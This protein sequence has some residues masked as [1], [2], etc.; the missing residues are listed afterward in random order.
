MENKKDFFS[1]IAII[2]GTC[3]G[4]GFLGIPYVASK[5]GFFVALTYLIIFSGIILLVNL[6]LGEIILRTKKTHQLSG[7]CGK[8]LGN[9]GKK[10]MTFAT[11]FTIYSIMI[12]YMIGIGESIG[13]LIFNEIKYHIII[14]VFFGLIM[15]SL[16][17]KGIKELKKVEKTGIIS[18]IIILLLIVFLFSEKVDFANLQ[19]FNSKFILFP[20][21]VILFSL[22]SF[23]SLPQAKIS[24]GKNR[25]DFKK[26]IIIGTLLPAFFYIIFTM[27]VVGV[28]GQLTPEIATFALGTIFILL[29]IVTMI[30]SYISLGNA[31]MENYMIDLN[32][33]KQKAW[34]FSSIL[35]IA[36]FALTQL[37][38]FFSFTKILSLGGVIS[39][40]LIGILILL[41]AKK[42]EKLGDLIPEYK[43]PINKGVITI[44]FLIFIIGLLSQIL[45]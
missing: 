30:T 7:Y 29:G 3:I 32:Y 9:K 33:K 43:I 31:L 26:V 42:A 16:I 37:F 41:T 36:T 8:Y 24:L 10:I 12:A 35:P 28:K 38:S 21:G 20:F 17:W 45:T 40:G 14:G 13:F 4:A 22:M 34:F 11:K 2:S 23:F 44:L 1:A 15:S 25:K 19:T 39:G 18:S 5:A 27:I 6:Y